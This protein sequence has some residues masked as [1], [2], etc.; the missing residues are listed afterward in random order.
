MDCA[1]SQQL[2]ETY[3]A[4]LT[5]F[6]AARLALLEVSEEHPE[7]TARRRT[8]DEIFAR[9]SAAR[10]RYLFHVTEHGC[11]LAVN[12]PETRLDIETRLRNE[13]REARHKFVA[14]DDR[15]DQLI[16]ISL[17]APGSADG[18]LAREQARRLREAA[19]NAYD[20][21]LRRYAEFITGEASHK[22]RVKE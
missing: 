21:A 8:K 15:Y 1:K 7:F 12:T 20:A 16:A 14:A 2:L 6:H 17:D 18:T 5:E 13:M 9:L 11:R 10:K 22:E 4:L 19:F 3:Y